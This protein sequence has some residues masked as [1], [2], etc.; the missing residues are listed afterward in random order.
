M[1]AVIGL[2]GA[3]IGG[4]LVLA[5]DFLRRRYEWN[6]ENVR[7][8]Q[9]ISAELC[10]LYHHVAGQA[11]DAKK[12]NQSV[13]TVQFHPPERYAMITRF[14]M[15]PGS[16]EVKKQAT[17]VIHAREDIEMS[18]QKSEEEFNRAWRAHEDAIIDLEK[19]VKRVVKRGHI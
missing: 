1:E 2:V 4:V 19:A 18:F 13:D 7:R 17:A 5:A 6:R 15:T 3:V 14:F 9:E 12:K 11:R 10:D 16:D 8:L